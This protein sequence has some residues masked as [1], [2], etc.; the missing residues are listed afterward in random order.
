MTLTKHL[1]GVENARGFV[2]HQYDIKIKMY[3]SEYKPFDLNFTF[4][5]WLLL[6][7]IEYIGKDN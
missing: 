1:Q 5:I 6:K 2:V 7:I 4:D 3:M